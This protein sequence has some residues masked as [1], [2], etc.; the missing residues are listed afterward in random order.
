[1]T[2]IL[3]ST[4][5]PQPWKNGGGTQRELLLR[6][7]GDSWKI[8]VALAAIEADGPFSEF[9]GIERWFSV[10]QGTG[11]ELTIQK[12]AHSSS[13]S[14][15]EVDPILRF[16]GA[17]KTHCRLLGGPVQALNLM[18]RGAQGR[19]DRVEDGVDWTPAAASCG[20]YT[21]VAGRCNQIDLPAG[22]LLWFDVSPTRLN[23]TAARQ[24]A[25]PAARWL[26]ASPLQTTP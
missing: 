5:K 19:I 3:A 10:M 4:V 9:A 6:P 8:R 26:A 13:H 22:A 11:L 17:A 14:L 18:L 1:M 16:D 7:P 2:I 12:S 20:L 21:E 25:R 15:A 24:T 23:F